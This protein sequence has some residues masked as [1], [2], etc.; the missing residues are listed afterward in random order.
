MLI[1]AVGVLAEMEVVVQFSAVGGPLGAF[2]AKL[3]GFASTGGLFEDLIEGGGFEVGKVGAVGTWGKIPG[4]KSLS[5]GERIGEEEYEV[6]VLLSHCDLSKQNFVEK[7]AVA[8]VTISSIRY[9]FIKVG[10]SL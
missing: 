10:C 6:C 4:G 8:A 3:V 1:G 5:E 7:R 2:G 9:A